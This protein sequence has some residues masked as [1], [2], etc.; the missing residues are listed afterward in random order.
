MMVEG[1]HVLPRRPLELG[2]RWE[3]EDIDSACREFAR[4]RYDPVKPY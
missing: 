4:L 1:Q 2:F 3:H